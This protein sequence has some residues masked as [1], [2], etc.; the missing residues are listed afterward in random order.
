M[1]IPK[2]EIL[3]LLRER[4]QS[5]QAAQAE[6]ELPGQVDTDRDR[7]MLEKYGLDPE[8]LLGMVR[9][10]LPGGLGDKLPGDL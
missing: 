6:Q 9:E 2:E 7:G 8:E 1:E 5:D 4:G 10:R 3:K